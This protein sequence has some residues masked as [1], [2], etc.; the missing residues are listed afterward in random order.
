MRNIV[1]LFICLSL[2]ACSN[3]DDQNTSLEICGV[4]NPIEDLPWLKEIKEGFEMSFSP[5]GS[6][7]IAYQYNGNDVFWINNCVNCEDAL[8]QIYN[9]MG[10]VI[11]QKGGITGLDECPEFEAE[12]INE[13]VLF[14]NVQNNQ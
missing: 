8:V 7:I 1:V 11:C 2:L 14:D 12:A 10:E 6:Q 4:N 3:D 5:V 9:C 13:K